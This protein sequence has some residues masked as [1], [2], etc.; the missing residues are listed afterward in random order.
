M[1]VVPLADLRDIAV[2]YVIGQTIL[3]AE[4][5]EVLDDRELTS[6]TYSDVMAVFREKLPKIAEKVEKEFCEKER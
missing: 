3:R 5:L 6:E 4:I 2:G 1:K